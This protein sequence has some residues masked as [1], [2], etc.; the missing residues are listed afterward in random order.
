[1]VMLYVTYAGDAQTRFDRNYWLNRHLPLVRECW[2][3]YGLERTDGFFSAGQES[4]L[5]AI[6]PCIFRDEAAMQAAL[7][8]SETRR[9]VD[10]VS[11]VTD[12]E[13]VQS[14]AHPVKS[15]EA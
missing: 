7:T 3:Q 9:I 14:V 5:I 10:D 1:M 12:A 2:G 13:P 11:K 4:G 8:S 6:C 15:Q